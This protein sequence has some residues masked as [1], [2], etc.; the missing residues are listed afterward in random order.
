MLTKDVRTRPCGFDVFDVNVVQVGIHLRSIFLR[1]SVIRRSWV[2]SAVISK[3]NPP[4]FFWKFIYRDSV[5]M[6]PFALHKCTFT[7]LQ[8]A[9]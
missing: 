2:G 5:L 6:P 7:Q 3:S 1:M 8:D 9:D 4:A